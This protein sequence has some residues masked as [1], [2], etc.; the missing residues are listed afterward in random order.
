VA[1]VNELITAAI[2]VAGLSLSG[3]LLFYVGSDDL[4]DSF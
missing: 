4:L 1:S 2:A 3:M